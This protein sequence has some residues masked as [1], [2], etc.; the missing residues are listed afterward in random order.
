MT[1]PFLSWAN[2]LNVMI[3]FPGSRQMVHEREKRA[4][5]KPLQYHQSFFMAT[6][7]IVHTILH[8]L[9]EAGSVRAARVV[10]TPG[11]WTLTVKFGV[12]ERPLAAHSPAPVIQKAETLVSYLENVGIAQFEVD[13]SNYIALSV[14]IVPPSLPPSLPTGQVCGA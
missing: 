11:G 8:R 14:R 5:L 1:Q 3:P 2:R 6:E 4:I 9:V 13:A 10:G 12:T 7:T